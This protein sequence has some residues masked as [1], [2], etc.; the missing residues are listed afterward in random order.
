MTSHKGRLSKLE[1]AA[2]PNAQE[3]YC[4]YYERDRE[5]NPPAS[6]TVTPTKNRRP[7]GQALVLTPAE[8]ETFRTRPDVN[9]TVV[10]VSY[11]DIALSDPTPVDTVKRVG[12]DLTR[13]DRKKS[14]S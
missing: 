13:I 9:L 7:S 11:G 10:I 8:F 3:Y 5:G 1:S 14:K 4:C 6:F 12:I 2:A